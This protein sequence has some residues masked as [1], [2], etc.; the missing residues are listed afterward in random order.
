MTFQSREITAPFSLLPTLHRTISLHLSLLLR[1]SPNCLSKKSSSE[2]DS[3]LPAAEEE[4]VLLGSEV[5]VKEGVPLGPLPVVG[6]LVGTL[7][8]SSVALVGLAAGVLVAEVK[9]APVIKSSVR[10][11]SFHGIVSVLFIPTIREYRKA[12]L[13]SHIWYSRADF[14]KFR[15]AAASARKLF[16]WQN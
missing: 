14:K 9:V 12:G 2:C 13:F 10:Y 16:M 6:A 4:G 7:V 1:A 15:E 5:G 8:G 11:V 3:P